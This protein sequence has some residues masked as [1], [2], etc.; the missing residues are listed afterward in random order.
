MAKFAL[1]LHDMPGDYAKLSPSEIERMIG[2]YIAW[3]K[4][5]AKRGKLINGEKLSD[6]GGRH[7]RMRNGKVQGSDGPYAETREIVGGL[8]LISADNLAEAEALAGTCPHLNYGKNSW[9]E[10]RPIDQM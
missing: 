7:L 9:I 2:A 8:Y 5:L 3:S 10:L 1:L 4:D 6:Q